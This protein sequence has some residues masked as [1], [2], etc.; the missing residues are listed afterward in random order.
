[1]I[2]RLIP[3][4]PSRQE[5]LEGLRVLS[6][7]VMESLRVLFYMLFTLTKALHPTEEMPEQDMTPIQQ[8][9]NE[10]KGQRM[11]ITELGELIQRQCLGPQVRSSG[12]T[13]ANLEA[14]IGSD[15]WEMAEM[16]EEF[17]QPASAGVAPSIS[18]PMPSTRVP[19]MNMKIAGIPVA[20][21]PPKTSRAPASPA[22]PVPSANDQVALTSHALESWG[23]KLVSWGRKHQGKTFEWTY[24][25]DQGYVKWLL[26]RKDSMTED[27]EDFG[28][29]AITRQRLE[30]AALN[31]GPM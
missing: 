30:S 4:M 13:L 16:E 14:T 23:R 8:L 5:V 9:I 15:L 29:Y 17:S 12:P 22:A 31:S 27:A 1:L 11:K 2:H 3:K 26:A 20:H 24:N 18:Q 10:V 25:N 19:A 28:N 6:E 21:A 7:E